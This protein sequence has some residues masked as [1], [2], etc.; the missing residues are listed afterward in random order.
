MV[1]LAARREVGVLQFRNVSALAEGEI[2]HAVPEAFRKSVALTKLIIVEGGNTAET[3]VILE[4]FGG[5]QIIVTAGVAPY[6][7]SV[8]GIGRE[9]ELFSPEYPLNQYSRVPMR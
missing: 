7:L 5:Q 1:T 2:E 9:S 8:K 4:A 3:G 6:T